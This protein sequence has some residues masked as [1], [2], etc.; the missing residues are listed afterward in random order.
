M[1]RIFFVNR[2][3]FPDHSATSQI[4]SDLAFHLAAAGRDV[5]V[6][7]GRQIY[8]DPKASLPDRETI[9]GVNVHRVSSTQYGRGALAGRA[10]DYLSFY[11]SVRARLMEIAR[12][13]DVVIAKTDPPLT[14]VVALNVT[15]R[16]GAHLINWLQDVYPETA[17]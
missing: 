8:D 7:T 13:G 1:K 3:F 4:L 9:N 2:Y 15:R 17:V 11:R 5:H 16:S 12:P 10:I 14:S 6:V